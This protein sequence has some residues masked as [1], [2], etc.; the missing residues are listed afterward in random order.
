MTTDES[1][2]DSISTRSG[3][4]RPEQVLLPDDLV[5][6]PRP[7]P[8]RERRLAREPLLHRRSEQIRPSTHAP[9]LRT[10]N[11]HQQLVGKSSPTSPIFAPTRALSKRRRRC[12]RRSRDRSTACVKTSGSQPAADKAVSRRCPQ[13]PRRRR[14]GTAIRS[15]RRRPSLRPGEVG[16][17]VFDPTFTRYCCTGSGRSARRS[18]RSTS[19]SDRLPPGSKPIP[20]SREQRAH[21]RHV[22]AG[23]GLQCVPQQS[24]DDAA[25]PHRAADRR[26]DAAR[27][28]TRSEASCSRTAFA[29]RTCTRCRRRAR[30]VLLVERPRSMYHDSPQRREAIRRPTVT[31]YRSSGRGSNFQRR[32]ADECDATEP[33]TES[34]TA[35]RPCSHDRGRADEPE[36]AVAEPPEHPP[37][38]EAPIR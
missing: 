29:R 35:R 20:R 22:P 2:S 9:R 38:D 19:S 21:D 25:T 33:S 27:A 6:R 32:A 18:R 34:T 4:P 24:S 15:T 14:C 23:T 17:K 31:S 1:R 13:R 11:S 30:H 5:E 28:E 7:Q 12:A 8:R 36:D 3:L 26:R 10:P 16:P 37:T